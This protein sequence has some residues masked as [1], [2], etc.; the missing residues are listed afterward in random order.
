M[1]IQV[2]PLIQIMDY[3]ACKVCFSDFYSTRAKLQKSIVL[4]KIGMIN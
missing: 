4:S 3:I 1:H 2:L